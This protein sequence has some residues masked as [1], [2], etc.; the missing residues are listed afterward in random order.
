VLALRR[1]RRRSPARIAFVQ[2]DALDM[3]FDDGAFDVVTCSLMLHH[4]EP[5]AATAVLAEMRRVSARVVIVNDL[6]RAWHPWLFARVV[7]PVITRNPLTR[8]D[9]PVSVLRA[10]TR[11]ELLKLLNAAGL[12]P[13]WRATVLGYRMAVL[14]TGE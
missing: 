2:G 1:R 13:R 11:E 9:G 4:F 7:G 12:T 3:P 14:A 10:Y 8:N 5:A 6:I